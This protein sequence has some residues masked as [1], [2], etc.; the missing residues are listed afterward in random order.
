MAAD[1][2]IKQTHNVAVWTLNR[3]EPVG[4]CGTEVCLDLTQS[5]VLEIWHIAPILNRG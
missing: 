1:Q 5:V 2:F 3:G 4:L